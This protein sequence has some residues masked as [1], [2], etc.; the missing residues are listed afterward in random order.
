MVVATHEHKDHV[1][2]FNQARG[3]F[4]NDFEF[5]A[6]WLGWTEN[7]GKPEIKKIK[8]TRKKAI[9]KLEAM[10]ASP[11]AAAAGNALDGVAALLGFS[12]DED[13]TGCGRVADALD[14]LK[15]RGKD[16][17]DLRY[18]EPG[19]EPFGLDGVEGAVLRARAA[20]RP[21]PAQEQRSHR[22]D[23]D[24]GRDLPSVRHR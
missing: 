20:A 13:E 8:E 23:E 14:Y 22:A 21:H 10:L 15:L 18:L 9:A 16:A 11:L 3:V 17:G 6:V 5:G 19:C 2:G 7:L 12:Q 4:N 1:S 24:R